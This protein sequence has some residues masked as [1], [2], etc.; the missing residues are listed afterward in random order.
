MRRREERQEETKGEQK[1]TKGREGTR[2]NG[3]ER[4]KEKK[5]EKGEEER[6]ERKRNGYSE[7]TSPKRHPMVET[8]R[9]V[10]PRVNLDGLHQTHSEPSVQSEQMHAMSEGEQLQRGENRD[11]V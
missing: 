3:M 11:Q 6:N 4:K 8:E 5:R 2:R 7:R 10:I 1:R 9:E